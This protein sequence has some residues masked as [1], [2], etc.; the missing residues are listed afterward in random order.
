MQRQ[1]FSS[2]LIGICFLLSGCELVESRTIST[3]QLSMDGVKLIALHVAQGDAPHTFDQTSYQVDEDQRLLL[4]LESLMSEVDKI[5]VEGGKKVWLEVAVPTAEEASNAAADL[6]LCP[7]TRNWM[8]LATWIYAHPFGAGTW[9][10]P[11]AD[12]DEAGCMRGSVKDSGKVIQFDATK[13]FVDYPRG[14][15]ENY[16][17]ALVAKDAVMVMG[18]RGGSYSPRLVFEN[19]IQTTTPTER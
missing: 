8:M 17:L 12:L 6:E 11:G 2:S 15:R 9:D 18:E 5:S 1:R 7:I 14:R 3:M 13:W 4:R 16:G 10:Q 19:Y